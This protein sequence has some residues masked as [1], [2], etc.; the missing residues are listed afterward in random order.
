[1]P[2]L[3]QPSFGPRTSLIY[4]TLGSLID[5]WTGVWYFSFRD[6]THPLSNSATFWVFGLFLTG[7][8]LVIIGLLLGPL[9]RNAAEGGTPSCRDDGRR[10][11][12]PA[13]GGFNTASRRAGCVKRYSPG[14]GNASDHQESENR[15]SDD[16][17]LP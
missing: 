3:S 12:D 13:D 8:T 16:L 9:G 10:G 6:S 17:I 15:A 2:M 11:T 4:V 7:L 14:F 1:M 5:V